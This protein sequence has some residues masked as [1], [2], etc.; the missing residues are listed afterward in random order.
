MTTDAWCELCK[1]LFSPVLPRAIEGGKKGD[2]CEQCS[3]ELRNVYTEPA[4]DD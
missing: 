1:R 4:Y 2:L 3:H